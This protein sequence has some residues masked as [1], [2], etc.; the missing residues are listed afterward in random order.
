MAASSN[1]L[2]TKGPRVAVVVLLLTAL[3]I[4]VARLDLRPSLA[5]VHLRLLSGPSEGNYHAMAAA[6]STAA[7]RKRGRIENVA[8]A[9]SLDNIQ[10]LAAAA[11]SC[12]VHAA[13]VQAGLPFPDAPRLEL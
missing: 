10:R 6:I 11:S 7:A 8:S 2:R 3:A 9:G 1:L 13:L 12:E 5:H 4:V